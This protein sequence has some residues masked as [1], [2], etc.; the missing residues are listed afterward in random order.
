MEV[1][2]TQNEIV[3][4]A[5]SILATDCSTRRSGRPEA[6]ADRSVDPVHETTPLSVA[7]QSRM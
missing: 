3:K 5:R 2:K 1:G 7:R 6:A 4:L